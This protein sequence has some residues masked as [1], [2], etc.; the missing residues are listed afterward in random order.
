[1]KDIYQHH[2]WWAFKLNEVAPYYTKTDFGAQ[3]SIL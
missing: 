2:L 1:M 3:F